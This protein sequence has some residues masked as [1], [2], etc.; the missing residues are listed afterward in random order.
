M[1]EKEVLIQKVTAS[2]LA[3]AK[4]QKMNE[5]QTK[6]YVDAEVQKAIE[7]YDTK[8]ET[9]E[10]I[11]DVKTND[12][13]KEKSNKPKKVK[14]I[15]YTPV[16]NFC[17]IIAGVHFA[18]GKAEVREGWVLNWFKEHGYKVEEASK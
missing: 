8:K 9:K 10:P 3:E 4:K 16:K 11:D 15:V 7:E 18:Y 6:L 2:A 13:K 12:T 1:D 14:Y 17:G 5:A